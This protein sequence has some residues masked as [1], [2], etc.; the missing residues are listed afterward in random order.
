MVCTCAPRS[1]R[2]AKSPGSPPRLWRVQAEAALAVSDVEL[3]TEGEMLRNPGLPEL[4]INLSCV[5]SEGAVAGALAYSV[6]V[7]VQQSVQMTRDPQITMAEAV[8]WYATSVGVGAAP[9]ASTALQAAITEKVEE[10]ATAYNAANT[11]AAP[12][13]GLRE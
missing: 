4:M 8:T 9:E 6:T 5:A 11:Q 12:P 3:L 13:P 10:F 2:C 1:I 7:Q